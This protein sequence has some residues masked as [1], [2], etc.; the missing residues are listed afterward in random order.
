MCS[1]WQNT[2]NWKG[3]CLPGMVDDV[4]IAPAS[5]PA[6]ISGGHVISIGK[7]EVQPCAALEVAANEELNS[8]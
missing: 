3:N 4:V 7:L 1:D 5:N 2:A 8:Q 6:K